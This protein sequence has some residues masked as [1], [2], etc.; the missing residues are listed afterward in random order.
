[1]TLR[2][3]LRKQAL[4]TVAAETFVRCCMPQATAFSG[5]ERGV[6]QAMRSASAKAEP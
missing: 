3:A 4:P 5:L 6:T 1:M 2:N